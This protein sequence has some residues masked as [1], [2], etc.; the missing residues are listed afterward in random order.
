[1][2]MNK[3]GC[4]CSCFDFHFWTPGL[5]TTHQ[6]PMRCKLGPKRGFWLEQAIP[7]GINKPYKTF[8]T[9]P[10]IPKNVTPKHPNIPNDETKP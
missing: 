6:G 1:M 5:L 10:I 4:S 3:L 9:I 7:A 2:P 8:V